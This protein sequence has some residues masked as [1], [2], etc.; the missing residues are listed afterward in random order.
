M[1]GASWQT[2]CPLLACL[3]IALVGCASDQRPE[4][5]RLVGPTAP[6]TSI[7]FSLVLRLPGEA[8]LRAALDSPRRARPMTAAAFGRAY[9]LP[10]RAL[11]RAERRLRAAGVR[12]V[13]RY[14]QRTALEVRGSAA[15]VQHLF[16]VRLGDFVDAAGRPY[17]APLDRPSVPPALA[18]AVDAVAGLSTRP[19]PITST[20]PVDGF[21]P[22][23]LAAA[24]GVQ[25]LWDQG[26]RGQGQTVAVVSFGSVDPAD[27]EAFDRATGTRGPPVER[28]PVEGG[29]QNRFA[30]IAL[31][32][33]L[34]V[35]AI[36]GI[37]PEAKILNYELPFDGQFSSFTRGMGTA[38]DTVVK[39]GR[40][41]IVSISYGICDAP[42]LADGTVLLPD[43]DRLRVR[44]AVDAAVR[45]GV[46]VFVATQDQGAYT[47][48]R[49][50]LSDHRLSTSWPGDDPGVIAV[51][52]T[53]L[54]VGS[55]GGYLDESGWEDVL[56]NGGGGGGLNPQDARPDWQLG[57]GVENAA[58][59]GKRQV[60]DVAA[61]ADP[62]SGFFVVFRGQAVSVGGTSAATPFW[63]ASTALVAQLAERE[64][65]GPLGHV[66]RML[67][68]LA[69]APQAFPAFHD[70]T[71][72]GN[73][74]Y[75]A[76][77]GWDYA[78]GLGSPHVYNLA[79]DAVSYLRTGT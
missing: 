22:V 32:V 28:I 6:D 53:L 38:I 56:S 24:Y 52:G 37:A 74:H 3:A 14:P 7:T 77:P 27:V 33:A 40:A 9:G 59:N 72:G 68:D 21:K 65:V 62:D 36:R 17:R 58:S 78:T 20:Q 5:D 19:L 71:R 70:V 57:P 61:A 60:P 2:A 30:G 41:K 8:K 25:P 15:A 47:C 23:D 73:R 69:R 35:Q 16:R 49:F 4:A 51:G 31:E 44:R 76:G 18:S 13:G 75:D 45:A 12:V 34:D 1:R 67:Y 79:R 42:T 63:A 29:N 39:D 54:S 26:I 11:R 64:R 50:L 66:S 48:Q 43:G 10:E 46:N 55:D